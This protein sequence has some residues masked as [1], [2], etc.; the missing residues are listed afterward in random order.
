M[1]GIIIN[2]GEILKTLEGI[3][4]RS[5][6]NLW[7]DILKAKSFTS[8]WILSRRYLIVLLFLLEFILLHIIWTIE[9]IPCKS[10]SISVCSSMGIC[11]LISF[12]KWFLWFIKLL[13]LL[14][15]WSHIKGFFIEDMLLRRDII[16]RWLW[17]WVIYPP[18]IIETPILL[19]IIH[20]VSLINV[21]FGFR[22]WGAGKKVGEKYVRVISHLWLLNTFIFLLALMWIEWAHG[23]VIAVFSY[24]S[25]NAISCCFC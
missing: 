9:Q 6:L 5:Q 13:L 11:I 8:Q 3:I 25:T 20:I 22:S 17:C 19:R 7:W 14:N 16:I 21:L 18:F 15:N 2:I 4:R 12:S 23:E 1:N 10:V 24:F